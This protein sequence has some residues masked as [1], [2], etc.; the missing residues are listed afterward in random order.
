MTLDDIAKAAEGAI[1]A[2]RD[3]VPGSNCSIYYHPPG[4]PKDNE[5]LVATTHCPEWAKFL[6]AAKPQVV[7]ALVE[8]AKAVGHWNQSVRPQ[9]LS[10]HAL[11]SIWNN[12]RKELE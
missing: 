7:I 8:L 10:E 2:A 1:K 11:V 4:A 9:G 5:P 12:L 6:A 3:N